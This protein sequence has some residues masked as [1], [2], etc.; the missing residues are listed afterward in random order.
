MKLLK[1]LLIIMLGISQMG[2]YMVPRLI[3]GKYEF[4]VMPGLNTGVPPQSIGMGVISGGTIDKT[5]PGWCQ[6]VIREYTEVDPLLLFPTIPNSNDLVI[7]KAYAYSEPD[8][9]G[10][11]SEGS[12]RDG[13]IEFRTP[14]K[15]IIVILD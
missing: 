12:D 15:P 4:P 10:N 3:N 5:V 6:N 13:H 7:L 2:A 9:E 1:L 11:M 8:C 14:N